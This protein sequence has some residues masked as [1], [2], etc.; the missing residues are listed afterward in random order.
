MSY[1]SQAQELV[2]QLKAIQS[3]KLPPETVKSVF[4]DLQSLLKAIRDGVAKGLF[5]PGSSVLNPVGSNTGNGPKDQPPNPFWVE[6]PVEI[7][8]VNA[9]EAQLETILAGVKPVAISGG[10]SVTLPQPTTNDA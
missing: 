8:T 4:K 10:S 9:T 1:L 3:G 2:Q 5:K 7:E 6:L